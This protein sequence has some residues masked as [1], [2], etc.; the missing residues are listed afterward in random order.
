MRDLVARKR[1]P[2]HVIQNAQLQR[3]ATA[4]GFVAA[5]QIAAIEY[6]GRHDWIGDGPRQGTVVLTQAGWDAGNS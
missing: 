1:Q 3:I 6:A 5:E 4:S 2:N